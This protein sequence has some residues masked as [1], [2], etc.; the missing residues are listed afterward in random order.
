MRKRIYS[1][2]FFKES[3]SSVLFSLCS[4]NTPQTTSGAKER[5]GTVDTAVLIHVYMYYNTSGKRWRYM[6]VVKH[7]TSLSEKTGER[8]DVT[9]CSGLI[10][11]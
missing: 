4:R 6:L 5:P 3:S 7:I 2:V 11:K 10:L 9:V 8:P 1:G